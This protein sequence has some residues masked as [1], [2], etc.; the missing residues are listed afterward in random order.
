MGGRA[1]AGGVAVLRAARADATAALH[2]ARTRCRGQRALPEHLRPPRR[3]GGR[4]HRQP[5]LRRRVA[6]GAGGARRGAR[7][8]DAARGR[9]HLPA[10]AHRGGR[11]ARDARRIRR[12]GPGGLRGHRG[13]ARARRAD[14]RGG[15]DGGAR[16]RERGRRWA[17]RPVRRRF[18]A[19]HRT[20]LPFQGRRR[21]DHQL[22]PSRV[23]AAHA[24]QRIRRPRG[25]AR[26]L[27]ARG[28]TRIPL[29]QLWR[30]DVRHPR[31]GQP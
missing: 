4:A 26:G 15:H 8:R 14:R 28:R 9:G 30:R 27:R 13:G 23:H 2:T 7:L 3:R 6:R 31:A 5:A 29:L 11:R 21:H 16:A 22:P 12:S 20:R 10:R 18:F 24:R 17:A 1:A 19:V 25:R